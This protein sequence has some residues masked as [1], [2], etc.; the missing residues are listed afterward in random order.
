MEN[1]G[2]ER[3][4]LRRD[5]ISKGVV[6]S[7]SSTPLVSR[8]CHSVRIMTSEYGDGDTDEEDQIS[9]RDEESTQAR[10]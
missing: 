2:G 6:R 1:C 7:Y 5:G 8:L 9:S 4:G 3:C 10:R